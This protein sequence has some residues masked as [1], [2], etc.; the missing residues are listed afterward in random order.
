MQTYCRHRA[1]KAL[2]AYWQRPVNIK[3]SATLV[4]ALMNPQS[5][6]SHAFLMENIEMHLSQARQIYDTHAPSHCHCDE[7]ILSDRLAA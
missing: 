3:E 4:T 1:E 2:E 7:V 5:S 6:S